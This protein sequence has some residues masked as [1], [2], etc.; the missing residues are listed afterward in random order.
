MKITNIRRGDG[1]GAQ[2]HSIIYT[3]LYAEM[4]N[5]EFIYTPF[6]S[7]EHNYNSDPD[8]LRKKE[9]FLGFINKYPIINQINENVEPIIN[10]ELDVVENNIDTCLE[11]KSLDDIK[12]TFHLNKVKRFD[13]GI[14]NVSV[15]VRKQN[16]HDN[17]VQGVHYD[18]YFLNV[19][20]I[21]RNE[22]KQKKVFHIYSQGDI[23]DFLRFQS[24]DVIFHLNDS[25]E[26]TFYDMV[27][28][29]ILVMSKS[30]FSY[31]AALLS[32]GIIYYLPFWHKGANKWLTI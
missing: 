20:N 1:F 31:S 32:D 25:I 6:E 2:L 5:H 7:M 30:S 3:I 12:K 9:D 14:L 24:E 4:F 21:I 10:T 13:D 23:N 18:E 22:Y 17:H 26:D 29:D 16:S 28:S 27:T 8:F 19:M 11:Y 15:H